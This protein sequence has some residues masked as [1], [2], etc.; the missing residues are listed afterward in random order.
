MKKFAI[1]SLSTILS[2]L[3]AL[4]S[5]LGVFAAESTPDEAPIPETIEIKSSDISR[6]SFYSEVQTALDFARDRAD[7][8]HIITVKV[9]PGEYVLDEGLRMYSNTTLSLYGVTVKRAQD[10]SINMV[11]LGEIDDVAQG[12]TGYHYENIAIEG[13]FFDADNTPCTMLK[14]THGKNFRMTDVTVGN[15][16]NSHMME[17]GGIDGFTLENCTFKN[18]KNELLD[19]PNVC[20]EAVQFDVLKNG[21]IL[22]CRSEDIPM[23]NVLVEGCHFENCPRGVGSHTAILNIPFE[24]MVIRNN[25]FKNMTSVAIQ[26]MSWVNCVISDNYFENTPRAVAVYAVASKGS[27]MIRPSVI[28]EEGNTEA[29]AS[30]NYIAPRDFKTVIE[31]NTIRGCGSVKDIHA[32]Y[33]VSAISTIGYDLSEVYSSGSDGSG[34][35]PKGNYYVN[36]V[37]IRNNDIEIF[38]TGCRIEDSRNIEITSNTIN[39][40]ANIYFPTNNYHGIMA[41]YNARIKT[42]SN[43]YIKNAKINGIYIAAGCSASTINYNN[44]NSASKYG[45]FLN[46]SPADT[47]CDNIVSDVKISGIAVKKNGSVKNPVVRNKVYNCA[48]GVEIAGT[49]KAFVNSNVFKKCAKN[50][51][52]SKMALLTKTTMGTNYATTPAVSGISND[53]SAV[54]ISKGRSYKLK[55]AI[56]PINGDTKITYSSSDT[57]VATVNSFGLIKAL[58]PGS[59]KITVKTA[60]SKSAV[61]SVTVNEELKD[62]KTTPSLAV[63]GATSVYNITGGVMVKWIKTPGAVKYRLFKK[64]SGT[65][66]VKI[67]ETTSLS[68]TDKKV[69]SGRVYTYTVRAV[70]SSGKYIGYYDTTGCSLTY[71]ASAKIK[72]LKNG[73]G[74]ITVSWDRVPGIS[75]YRLFY[76]VNKSA[77]QSFGTTSKTQKV[78]SKAVSGTDYT[79]LIVSLDSNKNPMNMFGKTGWKRRH[80][81]KPSLKKIKVKGKK[82]KLAW[83]KIAGANKYVIKVKASP[84]AGKSKKSKVKVKWKTLKPVLNN[85]KLVYSGKYGRTYQFML[86][87]CDQSGKQNSMYSDCKKI[88]VKKKKK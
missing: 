30:D 31:H 36:G 80:L 45:I 1:F 7:E 32:S 17:V 47:I 65:Q 70:D 75:Q 64:W 74:T 48:S 72:S 76:K 11:R 15:N 6:N 25:T 55:T 27:G 33:G 62:T 46:D 83:K 10:V 44:V 13:G 73:K 87:C 78:L 56:T 79:F 42:I 52:Y 8:N 14:I 63:T 61:V 50:L 77:W 3:I 41:R 86:K 35:L 71:F 29:H 67:A 19:S 53:V 84:K 23:K 66:F 88:N 2:L 5:A 58:N 18:Q 49:A 37:K 69:A 9:A 34:G 12:V 20:Y 82:I 68:Y 26:E 60:N 39:C 59:A 16:L 21:H 51:K 54:S 40:G 22:G 24:N 57:N 85:N 4:S 28:A 38:G 81:S 43:N